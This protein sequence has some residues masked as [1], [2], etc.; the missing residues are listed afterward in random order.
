MFQAQVAQRNPDCGGSGH[1]DRLKT[2]QAIHR[3]SSLICTA[4]LLLTCLTGLPLICHEEIEHLTE[5]ALAYDVVPPSAPLANLDRLTDAARRI[6]PGRIVT[7]LVRDDDEPQVIVGLAPSFAA[8]EADPTSGRFVRFDAHTGKILEKSQPAGRQPQT[9]IGLMLRLHIDLFT[10]LPGQLFLGA[11]ALLL[12][13]AIVSGALIYGPFTR[14]LAFGEVRAARTSRVRWLDLHSLLGIVTLAW[15]VVVGATGAMNELN[16]P[17]FAIWQR[18][19][20]ASAIRPWRSQPTL[21]PSKLSSIQSAFRTAERAVPGMTVVGANFPG[22]TLGSP[23]HYLLFAKGNTPL[24]SQL[25]SP[26][27]VDAR[28]GEL[29]AVVPMPWYLRVL[30]LSRPLHFGDYGGLPLKVIWALLD[31]VTIIVLGSGLYL[32][33]AKRRRRTSS[34]KSE[35]DDVVE[36][37]EFLEAAE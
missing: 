22:S 28:T 25:F 14:K 33:L 17:L 21:P 30:E 8:V 31:L 11:M 24:T 36:S 5:P 23:H 18:T 26:I 12:V 2:W 1:H 3:W 13:T 7:S 16:T 35:P 4:F 20:V 27:L 10:G 37:I 29:T 34:A 19:D 6:F 15:A 9:F 32:W